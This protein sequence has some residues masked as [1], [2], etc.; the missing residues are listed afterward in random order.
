MIIVNCVVKINFGEKMLKITKSQLREAIKSA[1]SEQ[2]NKVTVKH[3]SMLETIEKRQQ[4]IK[5]EYKQLEEKK[6]KWMQKATNPKEKGEFTRK[7]EAAG[8]DAQEYAEYVLKKAH[9]GSWKG[10]DETIN[11]AKF[12]KAAKSVASKKNK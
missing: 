7:A 6:K 10:S 8:M 11:Q 2:L 12:A 3:S 1:I 9:D 4:Q 5:E